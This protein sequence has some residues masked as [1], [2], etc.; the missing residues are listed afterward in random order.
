MPFY[1]F[2]NTIVTGPSFC[3][4]T[5]ISAANLPVA[6]FFIFCFLHC[7]TKKIAG[8][9]NLGIIST[10]QRRIYHGCPTTSH[11]QNR[12]ASSPFPFQTRGHRSHHLP[13]LRRDDSFPSCLPELRL[14]RWKR[15][16]S[17]RA[18]RQQISS[19]T[20]GI[21]RYRVFFCLHYGIIKN[22]V[23]LWN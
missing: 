18:R 11:Q 4:V 22:E 21:A 3:N 19:K 16:R 17:R 7:S 20:P 14:L 13:A 8:L 10:F 15:N 12:E 1:S 5:C 23:I 9:L 2:S 6:T